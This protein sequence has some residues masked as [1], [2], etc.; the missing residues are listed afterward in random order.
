MNAAS[1]NCRHCPVK[2]Q[3]ANLLRNDQWL[4][5]GVVIMLLMCGYVIRG[6]VAAYYAKLYLNGR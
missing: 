5:L 3:F 2:Q 1:L 6:S 4:I